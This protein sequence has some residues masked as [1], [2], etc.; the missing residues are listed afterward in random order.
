M[1]TRAISIGESDTLFMQLDQFCQKQKHKSYS[2]RVDGK[3]VI[4]V[5]YICSSDKDIGAAAN[6][7][8]VC[9]MT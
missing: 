3:A 9:V 4:L 5:L 1:A 7:E 2:S 8:C 6:V